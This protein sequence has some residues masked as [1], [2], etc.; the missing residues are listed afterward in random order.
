MDN[1]GGTRMDTKKHIDVRMNP[2]QR[3]KLDFLHE[4]FQK[5]SIGKV[6]Y[7]DVFRMALERLYDEEL[8]KRI[9]V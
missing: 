3:A 7:A 8:R 6:S 4:K 5:K 2:E 1:K 9:K